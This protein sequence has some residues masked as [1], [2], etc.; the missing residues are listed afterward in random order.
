MITD[1]KAFFRVTEK[2]SV[3][4][5]SEGYPVGSSFEH[6]GQ[7]IEVRSV[8]TTLGKVEVVVTDLEEPTAVQSD[9]IIP[10]E[11]VPVPPLPNQRTKLNKMLSR[12]ILH[13]NL[14][15]GKKLIDAGADL[16]KAIE[17]SFG[18]LWLDETRE[19]RDRIIADLRKYVKERDTL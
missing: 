18:H 7:Q 16:E 10:S 19:M 9:M 8:D 1:G 13:G 14:T 15:A 4:Y 6:G 17:K 5:G 11:D 12:A 3:S 2:E